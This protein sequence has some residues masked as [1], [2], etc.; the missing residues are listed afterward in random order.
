MSNE[1]LT[2]LESGPRTA[3]P[4]Q[5]PSV[6]RAWVVLVVQSFQRHWRVRQ[7]GW[8]S[9]A[10]LGLVV[11]WVS[12]VTVR[13]GWD[14]A[15]QRARRSANTNAEE[16]AR[17]TPGYRYRAL[18]ADEMLFFRMHE[19]PNPL[20]PTED[21][22]TSL[23]LSIPQAAMRSEAFLKSWAFM[24]YSRWVIMLVFMGFILPL[25]TLSYASGAFGTD[26][27]SRSLVWLMT[28]PIPRSGIYLAKFLG[29]LP[30]CVSFGAGGF[31]AVCLAAGDIGRE[32]LTR[33]WP[34]VAMGTVA[35]SALFHL[36]GAIF[37]RPVVVGLVYVFFFETVVAALPGS[38]KLLSLTFY[39]RSLM[40]NEAVAAG[41]PG[42]M[43]PAITSQAVSSETAWA[44]LAA[45]PVV[46]TIIG[47]W[48]FSRSEYRDDI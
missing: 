39:V 6:L 38:L 26:R 48:L 17:L 12:V 15:N 13:G 32:A 11:L 8:V 41:H 22:L 40:Y 20:N 5:L 18:D 21:A 36:I 2:A 43:L 4:D 34:A 30:W 7:M 35:F 44:V 3:P 42:D 31:V 23:M 19:V 16:A 27:E 45:A 10:L 29:T 14:L 28:R 1:P 37:R 47:M 46:I 33:Y 25:F 24:T 9:V